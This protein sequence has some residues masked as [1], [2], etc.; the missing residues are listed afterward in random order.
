MI[1][2]NFRR[3]DCLII[4]PGAYSHYS[5]AI[6]DC[7]KAVAIPAVEVHLSNIM[8]R[9]R[10]RRTLVTK[11]ACIAMISGKGIAGYLEAIDLLTKGDKHP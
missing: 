2:D 5:Y 8:E 9:E 7:L 3:F 11:D 1:H 10:F 4:N 6:Y